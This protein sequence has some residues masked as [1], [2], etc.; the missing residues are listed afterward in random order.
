MVPGLDVVGPERHGER[1]RRREDGAFD[2]QAEGGG[3]AGQVFVW[4]AA[5]VT[6]AIRCVLIDELTARE[7]LGQPPEFFR[8]PASPSLATMARP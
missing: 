2:A 5:W 4:I 1:R 7:Q 8:R 3:G 6:A